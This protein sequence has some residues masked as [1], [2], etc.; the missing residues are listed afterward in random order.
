MKYIEVTIY[1][2]K[3]GIEHVSNML[4]SMKIEGLIT[5]SP[6]DI[7]E[8]INKKNEYDW[9][10]IDQEVIRKK[11]LEPNVKF[12]LEHSKEGY[13]TLEDVRLRAMFLKGDEYDGKYKEGTSLG[14]MYVE[15]IIVDEED[16]K[17]NW[18]EYFKP[19]RIS[20]RIVIKPS[21]ENYDTENET[22]LIIEV[23]PGMAFGTGTHETTSL[24]LQ[25]LEKYIKEDDLVIDVGC[26]SGILSIGAA[27]LGAKKTLGI[28]IDPIAV[29]VSKENILLN[30]V[31]KLVEVVNGDLTKGI[32]FKGNIVVANLM[33]DLVIMLAESV[34]NHL[35][36]NGIFIS[37]GIIE[38]KKDL[39]ISQ[40][41]KLGFDII[42]A[43]NEA[44]WYALVAKKRG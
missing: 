37:S 21:W 22:D 14:R 4:I 42:E 34:E 9:D 44:E 8:L 40:L 27:K 10:Y 30:K 7:D 3:E 36:D 33:A 15:D 41:E 19:T 18:R 17:D 24:C 25:L 13:K 39:V 35:L 2:S 23:D 38:E 26:G 16:W 31:E 20:K 5:E 1:T 43:V 6:V 11:D 28:E 29:D 32:A 12:Y